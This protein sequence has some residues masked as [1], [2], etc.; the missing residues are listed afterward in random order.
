MEVDEPMSVR[1]ALRELVGGVG[2]QGGLPDACHAV[3]GVDADDRGP[4]VLG[5][6]QEAVEFALA[7]SESRDV[8]RQ[9]AVQSGGGRPWWRLVGGAL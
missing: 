2:D 6:A 9:R 1:V 5:R 7:A 4:P 3:D 8:A